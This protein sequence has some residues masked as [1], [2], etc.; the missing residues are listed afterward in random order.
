MAI[1]SDLCRAGKLETP[2]RRSMERLCGKL[3]KRGRFPYTLPPQPSLEA[4]VRIDPDQA[5]SF[6]DWTAAEA[7]GRLR[8]PGEGQI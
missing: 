5:L 8:G 2:N 7:G 3:N 6:I 4:V 1:R